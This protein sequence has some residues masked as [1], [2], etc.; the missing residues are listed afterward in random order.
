M[1]IFLASDLVRFCLNELLKK[2]FFLLWQNLHIFSNRV[3]QEHILS[4][5][6]YICYRLALTWLKHA[7]AC[8]AQQCKFMLMALNG[9]SWVLFR[10]SSTFITLWPW[11]SHSAFFLWA[12]IM[13]RE[14]NRD[15]M[16]K[17]HVLW[18]KGGCYANLIVR[19]EYLALHLYAVYHL[20]EM[21]T[22]SWWF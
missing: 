11:L 2:N 8:R 17:I 20:R 15:D 4:G 16:S 3:S 21:L 6:H 5:K 9:V 12:F 1:G 19:R 22:P 14:M 10:L 7:C 13:R 18:G